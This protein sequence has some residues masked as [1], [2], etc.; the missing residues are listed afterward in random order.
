MI[1]AGRRMEGRWHV[2]MAVAHWTCQDR[3]VPACDSRD[4]GH[5]MNQA[6]ELGVRESTSLPFFSPVSFS[7][8]S[9]LYTK[10]PALPLPLAPT[11]AH[12]PAAPLRGG[13]QKGLY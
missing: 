5:N 3:R 4:A 13:V 12:T 9:D 7:L 6:S 2:P 8:R 1:N 10:G 11:A